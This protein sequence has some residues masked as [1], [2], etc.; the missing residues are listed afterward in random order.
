MYLIKRFGL[1]FV[2]FRIDLTDYD[3]TVPMVRRVYS[4]DQKQAK[5]FE[6]PKT[7]RK[8]MCGDGREFLIK[9][10]PRRR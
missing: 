4:R 6:T 1:Y 2:G 8:E 7:A 5:R 3:R 9:L 10:K